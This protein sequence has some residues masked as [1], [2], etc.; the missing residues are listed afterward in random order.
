M[1]LTLKCSECENTDCD[2]RPR[3]IGRYTGCTREVTEE[4]YIKY[5]HYMTEVLPFLKMYKSPQEKEKY[6]EIIK[7]LLK[8]YRQPLG[9]VLYF[10]KKDVG[11]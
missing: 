10:K 1:Y 4:Q 9:R 11:E 5:E 6:A 3:G 8:I 7:F 2:I